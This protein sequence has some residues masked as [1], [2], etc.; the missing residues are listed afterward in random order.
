MIEEKTTILQY[1]LSKLIDQSSIDHIKKKLRSK[2]Y[3][4][5]C[6]THRKTVRINFHGETLSSFHAEMIF[7]CDDF[8]RD[9]RPLLRKELGLDSL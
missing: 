3:K 1:E 4:M 5:I 9:A 7:C 2:A 8:E 6:P